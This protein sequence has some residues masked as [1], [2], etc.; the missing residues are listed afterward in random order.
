MARNG[1]SLAVSLRRAM[2]GFDKHLCIQHI[3][4]CYGKC[5]T[6]NNS[7]LEAA[8]R[9][10]VGGL[11]AR[12]KFRIV[13]FQVG[14]LERAR[15]G[16]Q[17]PIGLPKLNMDRSGI[18]SKATCLQC[19]MRADHVCFV[20]IA[21]GMGAAEVEATDN[22]GGCRK[23]DECRITSIVDWT[24][25]ADGVVNSCPHCVGELVE[26]ENRLVCDMNPHVNDQSATAVCG[27]WGELIAQDAANLADFANQP[28]CKQLLRI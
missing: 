9:I 3:V 21:G 2:R 12:Q 28:F 8:M 1:I 4:L 14:H 23:A 24:V 27:G 11:K 18:S 13:P 6:V 5:L 15:F 7:L 17:F 16:M 20:V 10:T 26:E 25:V 22:P 19:A